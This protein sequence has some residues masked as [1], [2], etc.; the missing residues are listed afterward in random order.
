MH[1]LFKDFVKLASQKFIN[2]D[3]KKPIRLIS[4]IDSDGI[5]AVSI[6]ASTLNK[7]K[8]K[9]SVSIIS[10]LDQPTIEMLSKEDYDSFVFIDLGSGQLK[11]IVSKFE[12]KNVF[13]LD[14]HYPQNVKITSNIVHVNPMLFG[15]DGST[16]I[17]ASGVVYFFSKSLSEDAIKLSDIALI[18]SIGDQQSKNGFISLNQEILDDAIKEKKITIEKGIRF[19]GTQTRPIHKLLEYCTD[20]YIPGVTGSTEGTLDFLDSLGIEFKNSGGYRKLINLSENEMKILIRGIIKKR[21]YEKN[22]K[23]IYGENY[24]L[25]KED[26]SSPYMDAKE[27]S[28]VLNACGRLN[29]GSLG[30]AICMGSKK[31]KLQGIELLKDYK[32]E[33]L[34]AVRWYEK[35]KKTKNVIKK[36]SYIIINSQ[37]NIIPNIIGILASIISYSSE[38]KSLKY[39]ITMAQNVDSTTK[40][41]IRY[42][43]DDKKNI[44]LRK[45]INKIMKNISG[46]SGGHK[47]AAGALIQSVD[48]ALFIESAEKIISE[49]NN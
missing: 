7:L 40:I 46:H 22:P 35:N 14:H 20:P 49:I 47:Y 41:S 2:L 5:S 37:A 15:I 13:I 25:T 28:T 38:A 30:M 34:N 45:L 3:K 39:I 36:D 21:R 23:D 33:I 24:L 10:Q 48:E 17:C 18:G 11:S 16:E 1:I 6:L 12:K 8:F 32:K 31:A 4:H 44:D 26:L 42:S 27:F 19:F 9:Y 43:G 29:K